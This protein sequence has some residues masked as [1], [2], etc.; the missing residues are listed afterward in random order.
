MT[1]NSF[2]TVATAAIAAIVL[3]IAIAVAGS[4]AAAIADDRTLCRA[5]V[6][7]A[8]ACLSGRLCECVYDRGGTVTGTPAGFRWD[9][10]VLRPGCGDAATVPATE[11]PFQGPYP[12]AVGIDRPARPTR[13]QSGD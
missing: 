1:D 6:L 10:G 2:E 7:G 4:R 3:A 5:E 13:D 8:A 9:C 11:N 12:L